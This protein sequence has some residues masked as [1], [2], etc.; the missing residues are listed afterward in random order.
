MSAYKISDID[1]RKLN[2]SQE[3]IDK[4]YFE[5]QSKIREAIIPMI[6]E[7][8]GGKNILADVYPIIFGPFFY[9]SASLV[10]G[11]PG[12]WQIEVKFIPTSI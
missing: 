1:L 9:S 5:T 11:R 2:L 7:L 8:D 6:K 3:N 10:V 4:A 12:Y